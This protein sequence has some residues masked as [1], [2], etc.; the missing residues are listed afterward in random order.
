MHSW[1]QGL[2][3]AVKAAAGEYVVLMH[4]DVIVADRWLSRMLQC[5]R[6]GSGI[7]IV[8]PM[9]NAT[10][11]IQR[12]YFS[13]ERDPNRLEFDA[14]AF[15]A[16]NQHRRISTTQLASFCLM[17]KPSTRKINIGA[18]PQPNSLLFA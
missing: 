1:A 16:Q 3:Q 10:S 6:A 7:G 2:N 5:F 11:G 17:P 4:N 12:A 14:K 18:Y 9:T 8:G 13:E 15:Y